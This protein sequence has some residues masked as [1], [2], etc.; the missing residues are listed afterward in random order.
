MQRV[1]GKMSYQVV[2]NRGWEWLGYSTTSRSLVVDRALGSRKFVSDRGGW[3]HW[4]LPSG[5]MRMII[6]FH[7]NKCI[8]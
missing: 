8:L 3:S 1:I 7:K 2:R 5:S 6:V 4:E